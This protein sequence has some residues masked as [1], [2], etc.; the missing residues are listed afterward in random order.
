MFKSKTVGTQDLDNTFKRL[1]KLIPGPIMSD[2]LEDGAWVIAIAA[3]DNAVANGLMDSGDMIDSIVP[4]KVNQFRVDVK[5]GVDYGAAHE[6]GTT[7]TITP[8]QRA[9]FWYKYRSTKDGMWMALA[10]SETYTIKAKPYLRPA[11][12]SHKDMTV[13]AI[14]A[15]LL[16]ELRKLEA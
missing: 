5:V 11:I 4:V 10:L 6:Y 8:K 2:M 13:K 9:F 12:D 16:V 7:V 14:A 15:R 1:K 3:R